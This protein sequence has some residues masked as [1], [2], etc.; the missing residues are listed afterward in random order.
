MTRSPDRSWWHHHT[1]FKLFFFFF[2]CSPWLHGQ[3]VTTIPCK[4][5]SSSLPSFSTPIELF[6]RF[7]V[8]LSCSHITDC[9]FK[10]QFHL[11]FESVDRCGFF[12]SSKPQEHEKIECI[13]IMYKTSTYKDFLLLATCRHITA[14]KL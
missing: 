2:G 4:F 9:F 8:H 6:A 11:K 7:I 5:I 13:F 3:Q 12:G 14:E 1:S 10:S